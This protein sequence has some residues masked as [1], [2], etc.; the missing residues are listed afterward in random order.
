V[1]EFH[2]SILE[3]VEVGQPKAFEAEVGEG[4]RVVDV[5]AEAAAADGVVSDGP[6][7]ALPRPQGH[8][9]AVTAVDVLGGL[10]GGAEV[11]PLSDEGREDLAQRVDGDRRLAPLEPAERRLRDLA[12]TRKIGHAPAEEEAGSTAAGVF[13]FR[14]KG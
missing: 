9:D 12:G 2:G 3:A 14:G 11:D 5:G 7:A 13:I 8:P 6:I 10:L 1:L 4:P